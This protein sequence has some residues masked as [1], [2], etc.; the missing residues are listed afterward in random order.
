MNRQNHDY[1]DDFYLSSK[2][3]NSKRRKHYNP[4]EIDRYNYVDRDIYSSSSDK[5]RKGKKRRK[6]CGLKKILTTALCLILITFLGVF[7]YG[8]YMLSRLNR[9]ENIDTSKYME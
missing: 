1:R 3:P 9:S 6:K 8:K 2:R 5:R 7:A 4:D